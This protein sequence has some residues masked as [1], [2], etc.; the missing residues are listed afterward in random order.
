MTKLKGFTLTEI[1]IA[2]AISS[3]VMLSGLSLYYL[4]F[5]NSMTFHGNSEKRIQQLHLISSLQKDFVDCKYILATGNN[6]SF[7]FKEN[8]KEYIFSETSVIINTQNISDTIDI[9]IQSLNFKLD[10]NLVT[11]GLI[12]KLELSFLQ[13]KKEKE[14]ILKK[15][16][17]AITYLTRQ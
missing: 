17:D 1:I 8:K 10:N 7:F 5:K 13:F 14:I 6:L 11:I 12:N 4:T 2:L 15:Q 16:Y 9:D 3:I